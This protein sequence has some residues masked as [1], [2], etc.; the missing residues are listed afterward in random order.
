MRFIYFTVA[1]LVAC[2]TIVL[3]NEQPVA[4]AWSA[5]GFFPLADSGRTVLSAN[6]GWRFLRGDA[7]GAE[8]PDFDDSDWLPANLPHG[9]E[10]LPEEASGGVNYQGPAWYRTRLTVPEDWAGKRLVLHF[11]AIMGKSRIWIDGQLVKEHFGGYLPIVVDLTDYVTPGKQAV[12]AVRADNSNDNSYPPGKHQFSLDFAYFGGIYRNAWLIGTERVHITNANEENIVA[13]GGVFVY[14]SEVSAKQAVMVI[15]TTLANRTGKAREVKLATVLS[16]ATGTRLANNTET[17]KIDAG[18]QTTVK[19]RFTVEKPNL[20]HPDNPYL[21]LCDL[22]LTDAGDGTALDGGRIRVGIR[23]ID[24][25]GKDGFFLNGEPFNGKLIGGN[26]HQDFAVIGNALPNSIQWRDAHI[27]RSAGMRVVRAAHYPMAPAFMDACDELGL[28]VIVAT[29]GWQHWNRRPIFAERVYNDIRAMVRRDRNHPSVLLWEPI[30]NETSYPAEFAKRA[31][32]TVHLEYPH[33]GCFTASDHHAKGSEHFDVLFYRPMSPDEYAKHTKSIFTREWGD[34]VD[35]WNSQNSPS[36]VSRSW[37]EAA[38][39]VQF[40]H[41][42]KPPYSIT[43][44]DRLHST[45]AQHVGGTLWHPFDHQR[46]GMPFPFYGGITDAFRQKKL[47]WWLFASQRDPAL[48]LSGVE[49]GPMVRILHEMTPFSAADVVVATNCEEVRLRFAGGETLVQKPERDGGMPHP[50][51]VFKDVFDYMRLKELGRAGR[52]SQATMVAE[53]L[54]GGEVVAREVRHAALRP[55]RLVLEADLRGMPLVADGSDIVRVV[56]SVVDR[57][58]T[59][60]RLYEGD[61]HFTVTG[62][63][64]VVG[65]VRSGANPKPLR[66]GTA[67]ILIR[68]SGEPGVITVRAQPVWPGAHHRLAPAELEITTIAPA[69]PLV[70]LAAES[71]DLATGRRVAALEDDTIQAGIKEM[72]QQQEAFE[73]QPNQ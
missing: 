54:I 29:P 64:M 21:H 28:F 5:A 18:A 56:A 43:N 11:E 65:D 57:R 53:G 55:E 23:S 4:P 45:P 60:K 15:E 47:S 20:W 7:R 13:G 39:L 58:G 49:S 2:S 34:N 48:K 31:H 69:I 17:V 36:R 37:G 38:Q 61:V 71:R 42:G 8:R 9:L 40:W 68:A 35:T 59:V 26:R 46:G 22:R 66:W 44:L 25:R 62:P 24:F 14:F 63:G 51:V 30:L 16:N 72:E 6:G 33:P 1:L 70:T 32:E 10:V 52:S 12:I 41:Y 73:E 3:A 19:Q 50:P 27:L 67:P